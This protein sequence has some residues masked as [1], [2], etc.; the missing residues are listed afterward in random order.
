MTAHLASLL[1]VADATSPVYE[2][3]VGQDLIRVS[4]DSP[5]V[6]LGAVLIRPRFAP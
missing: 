3:D 1:A 6:G 4:P 5:L 2:L